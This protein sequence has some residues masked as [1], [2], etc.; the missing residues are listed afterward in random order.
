MLFKKQRGEHASETIN[1]YHRL[2]TCKILQLLLFTLY[3]TPGWSQMLFKKG[4]K[5][6]MPV[7]PL[8]IITGFKPVKSF[9]FYLIPYT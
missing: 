6:S 2:Q 9:N 3:F 8:I 7:K 1:H 5:G 4:E